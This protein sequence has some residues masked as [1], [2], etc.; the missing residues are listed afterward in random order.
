[1]RWKAMTDN[2]ACIMDAGWPTGVHFKEVSKLRQDDLD[3]IWPHFRAQELKHGIGLRFDR[4]MAQALRASAAVHRTR[5]VAS[6]EEYGTDEDAVDEALDKAKRTTTKKRDTKGKGKALAFDQDSDDEEQSTPPADPHWTAA[7]KKQVIKG[8]SNALPSNKSSDNK[9]QRNPLAYPRRQLKK[10]DTIDSADEDSLPKTHA[11]S[12][13]VCSGDGLSRLAFL[14]KLSGEH[15]FLELIGRIKEDIADLVSVL[16]LLLPHPLTRCAIQAPGTPDLPSWASW[17][18][19]DEYLPEAFY[20]TSDQT[21]EGFTAVSNAI[22]ARLSG[23]ES[24]S[25][26]EAL[27]VGLLL[28]ECARCTCIEVE[29]ARLAGKPDFW[30]NSTISLPVGVVVL[31]KLSMGAGAVPMDVTQVRLGTATEAEST[32]AGQEVGP[33]T[34]AEST[35]AGQ[36][37]G[38]SKKGKVT[39]RKAEGAP[40]EAAPRSSKRGKNGKPSYGVNDLE[41]HEMAKRRAH[42]AR[43]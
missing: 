33:V 21:D 3:T 36:E 40:A 1:M 24:V 2:P 35:A 42:R 27:G 11:E 9:E 6:E 5:V 31:E 25:W 18:F 38:P 15:E 20:S 17:S 30:V 26:E 32:A 13:A 4:K 29:E 23:R 14:R 16:C 37:V 7:T 19:G 39:K 28:R 34:D 12:P 22:V 41:A 10:R 8:K 43:K